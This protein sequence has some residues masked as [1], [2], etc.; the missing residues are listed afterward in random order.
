[1]YLYV[2]IS[3]YIF[4]YMARIIRV[5]SSTKMNERK[6][7]IFDT[8]YKTEEW[9][10]VKIAVDFKERISKIMKEIV[11]VR[12]E[13]D[14]VSNAIFDENLEQ[15]HDLKFCHYQLGEGLQKLA[16]ATWSLTFFQRNEEA[17]EARQ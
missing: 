1:L 16:D 4:I 2:R 10:N 6:I 8:K 11:V 17:L 3:A 12:S 5:M 13:L 15:D 9:T 14:A 7:N